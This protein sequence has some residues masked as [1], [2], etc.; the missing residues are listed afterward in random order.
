MYVCICG[1]QCTQPQV[2]IEFLT[3]YIVSE[4]ICICEDILDAC[5]RHKKTL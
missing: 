4:N 1:K 2:V 5:W 3:D